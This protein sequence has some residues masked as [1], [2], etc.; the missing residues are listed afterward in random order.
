MLQCIGSRN[1]VLL[2]MLEA[3]LWV[4]SLV[5]TILVFLSDPLHA[6]TDCDYYASPIGNG[7]GLSLST[8]FKVSNFWSLND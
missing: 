1:Q 4:L 2:R 7:N 8:P 5:V 6:I 3:N